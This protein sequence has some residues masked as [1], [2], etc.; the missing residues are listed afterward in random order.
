LKLVRIPRRYSLST[1]FA[2]SSFQGYIE[3]HHAP[4]RY[5]GQ[6]SIGNGSIT[7]QTLITAI[8]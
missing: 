5:P 4:P 6:R 2:N 7:T 1:Q 8:A 3:G